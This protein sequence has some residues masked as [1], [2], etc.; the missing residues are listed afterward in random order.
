MP[1]PFAIV[2]S[3]RITADDLFA[4][5][6]AHGGVIDNEAA[7]DGRVSRGECQVWVHLRDEE[8]ADLEDATLARIQ[9]ALGA[10]PISEVLLDVSGTEGSEQ[11]AV[12][13]A[14]AC[15]ERW[16]CIVYDFKG[17]ILTPDDL[18]RLQ[19]A[20]AGFAEPPPRAA[21]SDAP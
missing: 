10:E 8:L 2:C 14:C 5:L 18:S 20:G 17:R 6:R 7:K 11:L 13:F 12:D 3:I 9:T 15:A 4:A 1:E 19:A 21:T 16:P